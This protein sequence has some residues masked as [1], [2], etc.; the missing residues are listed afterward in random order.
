MSIVGAR[1]DPLVQTRHGFHIVIENIDPR[2]PEDRQGPFEGVA[3]VRNQNLDP[4]MRK[5]LLQMV[6]NGEEVG[7]SSVGEVIPVNRSQDEK[8]KSC[9]PDELRHAPWL[10]GIRPGRLSVIHVTKGTGPGAGPAQNHDGGH[11]L[12]KTGPEV[13][14]ACLLAYRAEPE[15][16]ETPLHS[17]DFRA[18]GSGD[19]K[20]GRLGGEEKE[21]V[22][23]VLGN[24]RAAGVKIVTVGQYLAPSPAHLPVVRYLHPDEFQKI[25][26]E[27]REMGFSR[28]ES[29]PLVRSSFHASQVALLPDN[30][31]TGFIYRG[32]SI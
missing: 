8:A 30:A 23:E 5:V 25:A 18:P 4:Q 14:T 21:E 10:I 28:V 1:P 20:P 32:I 22:R 6:D 11:T 27:A 24:M 31:P 2:F 15:F 17:G 7:G 16:P 3:E 19:T 9:L 12:P 26:A 29:G 13:G